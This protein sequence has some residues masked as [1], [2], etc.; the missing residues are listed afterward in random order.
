M[1]QRKKKK[2]DVHIL[3]RSQGKF[4]SEVQRQPVE[5]IFFIS[6][7]C[8][9]ELPSTP[10]CKVN[11][12]DSLHHHLLSLHLIFLLSVSDYSVTLCTEKMIFLF[13]PPQMLQQKK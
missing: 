5:I 10:Q 7:S 2:K 6:I 13:L 4:S 1:V 11:L 8:S 3:G 9:S 12:S